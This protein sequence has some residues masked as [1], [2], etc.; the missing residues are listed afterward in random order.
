M[1]AAARGLGHPGQKVVL[2]WPVPNCA[3]ACPSSWI[4]DKY[5]DLAC[6][7]TDCEYDGGDC[8]GKDAQMRGGYNSWHQNNA[9][10][11]GTGTGTNRGPIQHCAPGCADNWLGDKYCDRACNVLE[12][13]FD[14]GDCGVDRVR[15]GAGQL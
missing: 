10:G 9:G 4:G 2:A 12:C 1:I 3:D 14:A 13:G 6:N 5:C 8:L 7:T 15:L 11:T